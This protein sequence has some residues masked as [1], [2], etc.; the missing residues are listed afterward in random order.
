MGISAGGGSR[1][2][3]WA[4]RAAVLFLITVVVYGGGYDV[5]STL[6]G[7]PFFS[8]LTHQVRI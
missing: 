6:L 2:T 4:S 5:L 7:T 3:K 1:R 8:I